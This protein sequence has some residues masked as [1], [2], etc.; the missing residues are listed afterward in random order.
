MV[1]GLGAYVKREREARG[2]TQRELAVRA[3]LLTPK[4]E[5]NRTLVAQLETGRTKVSLPA[6]L[7]AIA[8]AFG[9]THLDLLVAAGE[10][11]REEAGTTGR[12]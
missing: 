10:L 8:R 12:A 5:P 2:W 3:N 1:D 6:S 9:V 4:G 7:R 11:T